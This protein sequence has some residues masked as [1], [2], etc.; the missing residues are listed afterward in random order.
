MTS[1]EGKRIEKEYFGKNGKRS[2]RIAGIRNEMHLAMEGGAGI[3]RSEAS[4]KKSEQTIRNLQERS[5]N[6][7]L[8]DQSYTFNT[9]LI[10]AFELSYMLDVAEAIIQ[11]ALRRTESRGSHQRTDFPKRDDKNFLA[12]TLAYKSESDLP[13]IEYVPVSITRWPP[14]ERVYGR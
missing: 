6:I 10:A 12:H 5:R 3:Y 13:R 2:E 9:E 14:G 4:L 1:D 8:S 7:S 11:S